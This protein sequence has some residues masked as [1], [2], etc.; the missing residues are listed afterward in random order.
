[1]SATSLRRACPVC[2]SAT[3]FV[4]H[5]Q[6]FVAPLELAAPPNY[7]VVA[8]A[9]C[10]FCFAD[11]A[12]D[13]SEVDAAYEAHSKYVPKDEILRVAAPVQAPEAAFERKRFSAVAAYLAARGIDPKAFV[14]DAGCATGGLLAALRSEGFSRLCGLDPS[15]QAVATVRRA[16]GVNA[17][18]GSF[19]SPPSDLGTFD[20]VTLSHTLE[21]LADVRRA[22]HSLRALLA[23][24]GLAYIEVPDAS[25]YAEYLVAPFQDFNTEHIN[26]FSLAVLRRLMAEHGFVEVDAGAKLIE[27]SPGIPYPAL[28]GLWRKG[29]LP[30]EMRATQR[31]DELQR[32]LERYV[33]ESKALMAEVCAALERDLRDDEE[34][35]IWGTGQLAMKLLGEPV[36]ANK[37]VRFVDSSPSRHGLHIGEAVIGKPE[38]LERLPNVPVVVA[39]IHEG[40]SILESMRN[41]LG[42]DDRAVLLSRPEWLGTCASVSN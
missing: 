15:P 38:E 8:C 16:Y 26:H 14:L 5:R 25:R 30:T 28:Y 27:C 2:S 21:H 7:E 10:G 24:G 41:L 39:S 34:I 13:Q 17:L 18:A 40:A 42:S 33:R 20:V 12:F 37:R 36:L 3:G 32:A 1:M 6:S 9:V 35:C 29:S 19:I 11:V 31:D 4:I 23:D 22:M